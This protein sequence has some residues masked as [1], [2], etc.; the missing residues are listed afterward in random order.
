[1]DKQCREIHKKDILCTIRRVLVPGL[2]VVV[3]LILNIPFCTHA[4]PFSIPESQIPHNTTQNDRLESCQMLNGASHECVSS[5]VTRM[6]CD[7]TEV[8][9]V[10]IIHV[11][12][13]W[14]S[15]VKRVTSPSEW[16]LNPR[17]SSR[18][19][20]RPSQKTTRRAEPSAG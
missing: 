6:H 12:H 1:M 13:K 7:V 4:F 9:L 11:V 10:D 8:C 20:A 14:G 5:T 19:D 3:V 15:V 16:S 18:S 2:P 17:K